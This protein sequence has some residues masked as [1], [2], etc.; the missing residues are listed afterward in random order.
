M[1][2]L[3]Y[4]ALVPHPPLV[5]PAVGGEQVRRVGATIHSLQQTAREIAGLSPDS[6]VIL[7]PHGP[8]F[9]DAMAVHCVPF[10]SG[11][12][13]AF[14]APQVALDVPV[15]Q[16][17]AEL[18][19][20]AAREAGLPVAPITE[21]WAQEWDAREL[22]HGTLVPL[23]FLRDAGWQGPVL[24]ITTGAL[25]ALELY[26]FGQ[27]VQRAIDRSGRR[28]AVLA[29]GDLSHRLNEEAPE[30]YDPDAAAWDRE[31]VEALGRSE[32][33]HLFSMDPERGERAAA[34]AIHPLMT[35]AGI[36][37]GLQVRAEVRSY[38]G[39]YGVGYS[40]VAIYPG[41]P[42]PRRMVLSSL[43]V[44]RAERLEERRRRAHPA[45]QLAR[46]ALD[47]YVRTG[48]TLD[49][50]EGA[51]HEGT[52][53]FRLPPDLPQQAGLFVTIKVDGRL[54]G[55]MGTLEP[56]EP[57]L[58]LEIIHTAILA[59]MEDD[60]FPPVEEEDLADL[61]YSIDLLSPLHAC[62]FE[63]LDPARLGL[64][65]RHGGRLGVLLPQLPGIDSPED[66]IRIA[67]SKAEINPTETGLEL[68]RFE[69]RHLH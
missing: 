43:R 25:N 47:H 44:Q 18:V 60:R 7:S 56:T 29:S 48:L 4:A 52:T 61:D 33:T 13:S 16:S 63:E 30:G 34:C 54:R 66:Q 69:V 20:S 23:S 10:I 42:D 27:A 26:A 32:I 38:E 39:P 51:P 57:T 68:Y 21:E 37:D 2:E 65:V 50:S 46:R 17:L 59:G 6:V 12:L 49:F 67:C 55:C 40:V 9:Q 24:P 8:V 45:V 62:R 3:V 11:N 15:D 31:L 28:I 36:L 19:L 35:L 1:Q 41:S 58:A 14:G 5:I 53:D 22:D 64:V